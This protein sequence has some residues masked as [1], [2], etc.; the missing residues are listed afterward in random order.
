MGTLIIEIIGFNL[1]N[2][3]NSSYSGIVTN[4]FNSLHYDLHTTSKRHHKIISDQYNKPKYNISIFTY[5]IQCHINR[6][7]IHIL[8][9]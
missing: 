7:Y 6:K 2:H 3:P 9:L 8:Y 5:N 4:R 1:F